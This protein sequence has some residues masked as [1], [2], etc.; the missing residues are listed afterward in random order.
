MVDN[1]A[2]EMQQNILNHQKKLEEVKERHNGEMEQL[3][4]QKN[5]RI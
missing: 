1:Q 3:V 4:Q 2:V 5:V